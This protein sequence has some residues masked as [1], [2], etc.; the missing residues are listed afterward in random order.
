MGGPARERSLLKAARPGAK[1]AAQP[2]KRAIFKKSRPAPLIVIDPGHGGKDPGAI[3]PNQGLVEKDVTLA[4]AVRVKRFL[5]K[6]RPGVKVKLTRTRD[7]F[8]TLEERAAIANSMNADI[9]LSIHCN[10]SKDNSSRGFETYYLSPAR[11]KSA[12]ALAARENGMTIASLS[13]LQTTLLDLMVCSKVSE[14][15]R[16]AKSINFNIGKVM[17]LKN[18]SRLNRGVRPGPFYVLFGAKAPAALVEC[19]FI[20]NLE[21]ARKMLQKNHLDRVGAG[22]AR[23]IL[24]FLHP[25]D[26]EGVVAMGAKKCFPSHLP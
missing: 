20:S 9:F 26:H 18:S 11:T 6:L 15:S 8:L 7:I 25:L 4:I 14:S 12:M 16:L 24:N 10:A 22:V 21:E 5:E 2:R 3:S 17:K 1:E 19:G 13:D 23:G